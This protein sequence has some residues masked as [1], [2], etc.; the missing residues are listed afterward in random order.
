MIIHV[1]VFIFFILSKIL[2]PSPE[3]TVGATLAL[4][5]LDCNNFVINYSIIK[6]KV[7]AK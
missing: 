3:E 6:T 7:K 2:D 5:S 4:A 1:V